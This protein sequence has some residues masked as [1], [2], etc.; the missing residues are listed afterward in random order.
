M[1]LRTGEIRIL[2]GK[3]DKHRSVAIDPSPVPRRSAGWFNAGS[4]STPEWSD[5]C[6]VLQFNGPQ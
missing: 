1:N 5:C 6:A 4:S 2:H 3:C